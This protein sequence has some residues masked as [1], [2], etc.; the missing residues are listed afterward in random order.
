MSVGSGD[1]RYIC[2]TFHRVTWF[3]S[4]RGQ[5]DLQVLRCKGSARLS[6]ATNCLVALLGKVSRLCLGRH[7]LLACRAGLL[8]LLLERCAEPRRCLTLRLF[9]CQPAYVRDV[10]WQW[11]QYDDEAESSCDQSF[12]DQQP[13]SGVV[14]ECVRCLTV[15]QPHA[16]G[17]CALL[18]SG[19]LLPGKHQ[20]STTAE[21][22]VQLVWQLQKTMQLVCVS[23]PHTSASE[24]PACSPSVSPCASSAER[25]ACE[26]RTSATS[27]SRQRM[28]ACRAG[29]S[30][31]TAAAANS[32][33]VCQVA[34]LG[35]SKLTCWQPCVRRMQAEEAGS[36]SHARMLLPQCML[37]V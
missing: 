20:A 18:C 30:S 7:A 26:A 8:H 4:L 15:A 1:W 17:I 36:M 35:T 37:G 12:L 27:R 9:S 16:Q 13:T 32:L 29:S 21:R 23:A 25:A 6:T 14:H 33:H 28:R 11:V 22:W 2:D 34:S 31:A 5:Y 24:L 19:N 3:F 10:D